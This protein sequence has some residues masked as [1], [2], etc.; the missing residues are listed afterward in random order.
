MDNE[1]IDVNSLSAQEKISI[2]V[3]DLPD[4]IKR[5]VQSPERDA[6]SLK[7]SQKYNLHADD[8]GVFDQAYIFM[9]LGIYTPDEF[10]SQ[11]RQASFNPDTIRGLT[12][13]VNEMVFKKL[14]DE[15]QKQSGATEPVKDTAV[16]LMNI[17]PRKEN[18]SFATA[19]QPPFGAKAETQEY[20]AAIPITPKESQ[21]QQVQQVAPLVVTEIPTQPAPPQPVA[22]VAQTHPRTMQQ[23]MQLVQQGNLHDAEL[24]VP[25]GPV[26]TP[27]TAP[28]ATPTPVVA[29]PVTAPTAPQY[30]ARPQSIASTPYTPPIPPPAWHSSAAASFQTAS[31][32]N[33]AP[34]ELNIPRYAMP[35]VGTPPPMPEPYAQVPQQARPAQVP[36]Y[37]AASPI[38]K[39]YGADPYREIPQ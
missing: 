10:V 23:D 19:A 6:V 29:A 3:E 17:S 32:P 15:E 1:T 30:A 21:I 26:A 2:L 13:D 11:L 37:S 18:S 7:L 25:V 5:F 4:P 14:R 31:I 36:T 16:P 27:Y 24:G 22:P 33:T 34:S 12:N 35:T 39:E 38:K 9:L 8:A 20:G 28:A